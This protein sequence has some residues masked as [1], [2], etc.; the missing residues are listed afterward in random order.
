MIFT[1]FV[2]ECDF[3]VYMYI[4]GANVFFSHVFKKGVVL[5]LFTEVLIIGFAVVEFMICLSDFIIDMFEG[6]G[7]SYP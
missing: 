1:L 4:L 5:I 2:L 6:C 3:H 7:G